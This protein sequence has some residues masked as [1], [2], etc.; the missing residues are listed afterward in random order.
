MTYPTQQEVGQSSRA[1]VFTNKYENEFVGKVGLKVDFDPEIADAGGTTQTFTLKLRTN[2][3]EEAKVQ[4]TLGLIVTDDAD[5]GTP[6]NGYTV[7]TATK[8]TIVA[9]ADSNDLVIKTDA[10]GEFAATLTQGS[11]GAASV[12]LKVKPVAGSPALDASGYQKV[13]FPAP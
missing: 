2:P 5:G 11:A 7:G 8:G 1:G 6:L 3:G 10:N 12:Y 4:E 9:G 13:S